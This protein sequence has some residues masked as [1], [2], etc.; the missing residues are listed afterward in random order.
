MFFPICNE[1]NKLVVNY[2]TNTRYMALYNLWGQQRIIK[3]KSC[4]PGA[5]N[6]CKEIKNWKYLKVNFSS[7]SFEG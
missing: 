2:S 3:W 4:L 7:Q 1:Q 5:Y 6:L